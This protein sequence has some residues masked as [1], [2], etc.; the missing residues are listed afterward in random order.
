MCLGQG[1]G[2]L[3]DFNGVFVWAG[4]PPIYVNLQELT[5]GLQITKTDKYVYHLFIRRY[6]YETGSFIIQLKPLAKLKS[7]V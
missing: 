6:F 2:L 3:G 5:K 7:F 1:H 4:R